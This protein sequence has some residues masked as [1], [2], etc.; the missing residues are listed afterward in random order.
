VRLGSF[1]HKPAPLPPC[2][3]GNE[4]YSGAGD[5]S[6]PYGRAFPATADYLARIA[7]AVRALRA[8]T[9]WAVLAGGVP[10]MIGRDPGNDE[11]VWNDGLAANA[12]VAAKGGV[13]DGVTAHLYQPAA[14]LSYMDSLAQHPPA[15]WPSVLAAAPERVVGLVRNSTA[16]A[17]KGAPVLWL[18][19]TN[20][21][22]GA[23]GVRGLSPASEF[24]TYAY[25]GVPHHPQPVAV[26][27]FVLPG[28]PTAA[29]PGAHRRGRRRS[30]S[31]GAGQGGLP[32]GGGG[33]PSGV[34]DAPPL[35]A[36][37]PGPAR[38]GRR[39][40]RAAQPRSLWPRP[41]RGALPAASASGLCPGGSLPALTARAV[42]LST[43]RPRA[44]V[45]SAGS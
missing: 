41:A 22:G 36:V 25:A 9:R 24:A 16:A 26:R 39:R 28:H 19:E 32:P 31:G 27:R 43:G 40:G 35:A 11:T 45:R 3:F 8:G 12:S 2:R 38:R 5:A 42:P 34:C 14:N 29:R 21:G 4:L 10:L 33:G 6:R 30:P 1:R 20:M 23:T 18:T 44:G 7:P 13:F 15:L 17:L 37:G